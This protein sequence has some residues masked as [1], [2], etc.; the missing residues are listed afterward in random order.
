MSHLP[1]PPVRG[2]WE[3]IWLLSLHNL[4]S[5]FLLSSWY[6]PGPQSVLHTPSWSLHSNPNVL[7]CLFSLKS[8]LSLREKSHLPTVIQ[9][10]TGCSFLPGGTPGIWVEV[11]PQLIK[12]F[13]HVLYVVLPHTTC[14]VHEEEVGHGLVS[15]AQILVLREPQNVCYTSNSSLS[16]SFFFFHF[17]SHTCG[18]W[19]FPGK[20]SNRSR[21]CSNTRSEPHLW[22][23]TDP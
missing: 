19:T 18:R 14:P 7:S 17:Y 15:L 2:M 16:L 20:R 11:S 23:M 4:K 6:V 10:S 12:A 5:Y 3:L 8:K 13:T 22:L 9:Q 1:V 21:S